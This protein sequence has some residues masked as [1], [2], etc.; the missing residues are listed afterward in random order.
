[1]FKGLQ[2]NH[3]IYLYSS[4]NAIINEIQGFEMN[5]ELGA[6]WID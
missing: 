4:N 5:E 1:M 2:I 3:T 6:K